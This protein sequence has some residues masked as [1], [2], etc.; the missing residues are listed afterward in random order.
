MILDGIRY[1]RLVVCCLAFLSAMGSAKADIGAWLLLDAETGQV[2]DEKESFRQWYPASLTKM[3]TAYVVFSA[4]RA[5]SATTDSIVV[6]SKSAAAEP[7]SKMGFPIGTELTVGNAVKI[8]LVKSANDVAV[9][10]AQSVGGSTE[11]FVSKMNSEATRLGMTSTIFTNPHGLP[12][13]AQVTTARDMA[14]LARAL[15]R[16]F[17][18][19]RDYYA[20]TGIQFGKRVLKSAN[21]EFLLRVD[22]AA[23]I[24][25]GYICNSGYNVAAAAQRG[26][27]TLIAVIL[28]AGS[29]TERAAFASKAINAGFRKGWVLPEAGSTIETL[30]PSA[31]TLLPPAD[32]YCRRNKPSTATL[33]SIYAKPDESE[34]DL[35]SLSLAYSQPAKDK[36]AA[37]AV[38]LPKK[39]GSRKT[40]WAKVLDTIVGPRNGLERILPVATG[41]P[42]GAEL[43]LASRGKSTEELTGIYIPVPGEKPEGPLARM[44][45]IDDLPKSALSRTLL[46]NAKPGS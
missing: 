18:Q 36:G 1:G 15:W 39:K 28:G 31:T 11:E 4:I 33:Y 32:G 45:T 17:P 24:K 14:I 26:G 21:R 25:T 34:A 41:V 9:A 38:K 10:L 22:G 27:R 29:G 40:D 20:M 42:A 12:D 30:K 43:P 16:D 23:G 13:N 44:P 5:G 19:Y 8:L 7:P 35:A 3:M 6:M 37:E 46:P 2:L